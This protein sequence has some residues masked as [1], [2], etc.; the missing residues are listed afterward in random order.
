MTQ[1]HRPDGPSR[2]YAVGHGRPPVATRFQPGKSGNP[3]GRPKGLKSINQLLRE[4]L[5]RRVVVHENGRERRIRL[6]DV[7]I[8]G[9]VADAAR[10][11][12]NALKLL[13]SLLDRYGQSGETA[14]AAGALEAD[15]SAIIASYFAMLQEGQ[16][17]NRPGTSAGPER[18]DGC[19]KMGDDLD[20]DAS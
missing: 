18:L 1:R 7:I 20:R 11:N 12:V 4:A 15:D 13:F 16:A 3:R 10:R 8:Q 6:Q 17:D 19:S 14:I 5:S 2:E 9:L